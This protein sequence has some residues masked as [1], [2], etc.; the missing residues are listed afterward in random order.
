M[1]LSQ[2]AESAEQELY[3]R[4]YLIYRHGVMG[5]RGRCQKLTEAPARCVQYRL[6]RQFFFPLGAVA[7]CRPIPNLLGDPCGCL[8]AD[9]LWEGRSN[10]SLYRY[11]LSLASFTRPFFFERANAGLDDGQL[12]GQYR[13]ERSDCLVTRLLGYLGAMEMTLTDAAVPEGIATP[14]TGLLSP[15]NPIIYR[16]AP[17]TLRDIIS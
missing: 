4:R 10:P 13:G 15:M 12:V 11:M 7:G 14:E 1:P 5:L 2:R 3:C 17:M 6:R 16:A 8:S 9:P